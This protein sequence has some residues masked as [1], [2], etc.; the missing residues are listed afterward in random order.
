MLSFAAAAFLLPG[1]T[2]GATPGAYDAAVHASVPASHIAD[3]PPGTVS[4][5]HVDVVVRVRHATI[6][7][8]RWQAARD[9]AQVPVLIAAVWLLRGVLRSVRDAD[10]FTQKNVERLRA[11]A[12][13]VLVGLPI[14]GFVSSM[15][16]NELA[17]S[18]GLDGPGTAVGIPGNAVLSG[19]ALF[20][21]AE[22]FARGVALRD[23]LE[24]TV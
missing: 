9:L 18:A 15:F 14:A 19:L 13:V 10:P 24:G 12:V 4:P 16:A 5:D 7:Q 11:L 20:A 3:L 17:L 2:F 23:D 8:R 1:V 21:L 22:V 6:T